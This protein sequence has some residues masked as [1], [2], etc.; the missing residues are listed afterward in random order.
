MT[1]KPRRPHGTGGVYQEH[2]ADCPKPVDGERPA[3]TCKGRWVGS[4]E[5]GYTKS[6]AR[7]RRKVIGKTKT[8]AQQ[9]L[10][11]ALRER[12]SA[13]APTSGSRPTVKRWSD[14]WLETTSHDLRPGTWNANRSLINNWIVPTIGHRRLADLTPG[15]VREVRRAILGAGLAA[16]T[17]ARAHAVLLWS[18]KDAVREGHDVSRGALLTEGPDAGE[19]D[20]GDIPLADAIAILS[21]AAARPDASRWVAAFLLGSRPAET[22]GITWDRCDFEAGIID[23][24]WQLKPL[25]YNVPRDRS[26]GF[27]VPDN[28]EA[29]HLHDAMHLVRPKTGKGKRTASMEGMAPLLLAWRTIAPQS[30]HGLVWPRP[31]GRGRD[32]KADRDEWRDLQDEAQVACVDGTTG[33]RYDLYEA[34]HTAATLRRALGADDETIMATLGHASI[35]SSKAYL[36]TDKTRQHQAQSLVAEALG[37]L[38]AGADEG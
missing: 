30:P 11:K 35:L 1:G 8:L 20:R 38:V 34:R 25:P 6:G 36:H 18:L 19:S 33:R 10:I 12:D 2:G 27:R 14:T 17:A 32:D 7:R 29:R 31:D 28:H 16:S 9:K 13:Q 15:H 26:S 3:H 24:S 5:D 21:V 4:Y 23:I 22:L 37:L